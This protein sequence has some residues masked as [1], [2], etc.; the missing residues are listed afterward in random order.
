MGLNY[1]AD[2]IDAPL[3]ELLRQVSINT[4]NQLMAFSDSS[5][6]Y[7]PD[8][9]ITTGAYIIFYQR[10]SIDHGTHVPG[11]V[12]R[13]SAESEYNVEFTAGMA[14]SH[15]RMLIHELLN[16]YPDIVP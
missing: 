1:Y 14:L 15:F 2:I 8:N 5:C 9:G 13:S 7:C 11:L 10:G 4:E 3:N 12:S 16:K 6:K